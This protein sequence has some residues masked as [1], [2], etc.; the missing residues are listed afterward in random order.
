MLFPAASSI[1]SG[2]L[3]FAAFTLFHGQLRYSMLL[4]VGIAIILFVPA[5][6]AVTQDVVHP[7]LRAVSLSL[8][9]VI[10]HSLGSPLGPLFVGAVSDAYGIT[11]AMKLL[12]IFTLLAG[13]L[14]LIGS[15]FY[16]DDLARVEKVE[17]ELE[18]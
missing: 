1:L 2:L 7:G 6:V 12:P 4:L 13:V 18:Q 14:F 11:T 3:L 16:T 17:P 10:Q 9:V 15:C 5:G 8:N